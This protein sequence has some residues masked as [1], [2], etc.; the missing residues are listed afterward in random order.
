LDLVHAV[1]FDEEL[2][3]ID[4]TAFEDS[5]SAR[6]AA[7]RTGSLFTPLAR[8]FVEELT[9]LQ[10]DLP[11]DELPDME[12]LSAVLYSAAACLA[13][14]QPDGTTDR[15][16]AQEFTDSLESFMQRSDQSSC[17]RPRGKE[18]LATAFGLAFSMFHK[19]II[20]HRLLTDK[21]NAAHSSDLR[22]AIIS[23]AND[24]IW[25]KLAFLRTW[26]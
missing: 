15:M 4:A 18:S 23:M 25:K 3:H 6:E 14:L 10:T 20:D 9:A 8:L 19:L 26:M 11:P 16:L 24:A 1:L 12:S 22:Q 17:D 21:R 2:L 7:T 13:S 5:G